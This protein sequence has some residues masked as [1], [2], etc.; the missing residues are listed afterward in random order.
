MPP[1]P[2]SSNDVG[3]PVVPSI[4]Q[5]TGVLACPP[6]N[7]AFNSP[8]LPSPRPVF[9]TVTVKPIG[10]PADT[11]AASAV[12]VTLIAAHFTSSEADA[13]LLPSLVVVASAVLL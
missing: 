6:G 7:A 1:A 13:V 4:D 3:L 10:D 12:L 2:L 11:L 9:S 5:V 8:P